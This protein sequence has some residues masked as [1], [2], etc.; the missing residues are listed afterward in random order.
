MKPPNG[1]ECG[2]GGVAGVYDPD[3]CPCLFHGTEDIWVDSEIIQQGHSGNETMGQTA[4]RGS[5]SSARSLPVTVEDLY[6]AIQTICQGIKERHHMG[7]GMI[8]Q[9]PYPEWQG[10]AP[11][12][13]DDSIR[14]RKTFAGFR[15]G[16]HIKNIL[17]V[18]LRVDHD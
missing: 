2:Q 11:S 12:I 7:T 1:H 9:K 18:A 3:V 6:G 17:E 5:P 8:H 10:I 15:I 16:Y 13:F 14:M 4:Q